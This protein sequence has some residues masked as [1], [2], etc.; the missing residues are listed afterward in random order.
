MTVSVKNRIATKPVSG[1]LLEEKDKPYKGPGLTG[2]M[3]L[4]GMIS[5]REL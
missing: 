1:L 2:A 5:T 3:P 4:T